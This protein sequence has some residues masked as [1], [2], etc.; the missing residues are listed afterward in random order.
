MSKKTIIARIVE[1]LDAID[2]KKVREIERI[3]IILRPASARAVEVVRKTAY[4]AAKNDK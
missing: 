1:L 3:I 2:E 4:F